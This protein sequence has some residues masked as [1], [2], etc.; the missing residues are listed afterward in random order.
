VKKAG[1]IIVAGLSIVGFVTLLLPKKDPPPEAA[2]V[3][4]QVL[5]DAP[6]RPP[7]AGAR[8]EGA[9]IRVRTAADGSVLL[10]RGQAEKLRIYGP[11]HAGLHVSVDLSKPE[12]TIVL[13]RTGS[14][15]FTAPV[16]GVG[17]RVTAS[18]PDPAFIVPGVDP[19]KYTDK[20]GVAR[21]DDL[22]PGMTLAWECTTGHT[23]EKGS[24]TVAGG[25]EMRVELNVRPTSTVRFRL[26]VGRHAG[27]MAHVEIWKKDAAERVLE[28]SADVAVGAPISIPNLAS[29]PKFVRAAWWD[30]PGLRAYAVTPFELGEKETRDLGTIESLKGE[31]VGIL[32]RIDA[33]EWVLKALSKPAMAR[34]QIVTTPSYD[35]PPVVD[36]LKIEAGRPLILKGIAAER[37]TVACLPE[38]SFQ[39]GGETYT[40]EAVP[41]VQVTMPAPR[42]IEIVIKIRSK[43]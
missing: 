35:G 25:E 41:Q 42:P 40:I 13:Q 20:T 6:G 43:L 22:A 10:A 37:L 26:P 4:V 7:I 11:R 1:L 33:A 9:K 2:K 34:L 24:F 31:G 36:D 38:F 12:Q 27:G 5:S 32:V 30:G 23:A 16:E 29:G 14:A 21:W 18:G 15:R 17:I 3:R 19:E 28:K 8:I 39:P